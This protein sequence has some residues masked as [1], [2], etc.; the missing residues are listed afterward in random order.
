MFYWKSNC[1]AGF[2]ASIL[3]FGYTSYHVLLY[4]NSSLYEKHRSTVSLPLSYWCSSICPLAE[5]PDSCLLGAMEK[6][7]VGALE[8]VAMDM[9]AR[10]TI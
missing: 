8:L 6:G 5:V 1:F 10:S 7:G 2:L 9:K 3:C 4:F